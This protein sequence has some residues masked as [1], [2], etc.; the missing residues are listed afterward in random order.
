MAEKK[1][2]VGV[3]GVLIKNDKVLLIKG[4]KKVEGRDHWEVPGGRI[5]NDETID[6]ALAREL[7]EEVGATNIV[8]HEV[9]HA[10]RIDRDVAED[11]GLVLIFFRIS[12]DISEVVL[13]HEHVEHKWLS[14]DEAVKLAHPTVA[15]AIK[16]AYKMAE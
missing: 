6:Q 1:F 12:A 7:K 16:N 8:K 13:S 9:V 3:K 15:I 14:L 5:D 2:Y 11:T 10:H 4:N